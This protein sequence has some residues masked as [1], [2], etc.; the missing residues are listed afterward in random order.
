MVKR[1]DVATYNAMIA[2]KDDKWQAGTLS[3]G[4][5]EDGL[6]YAIDDNNRSLIAAE[7]KARVDQAKADI[8]AGKIVPTDV[9]AK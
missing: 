5:K 9:A 8:I 7:T 6:D 3:L 1:V 2:A 4:L